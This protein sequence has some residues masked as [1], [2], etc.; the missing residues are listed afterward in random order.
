MDEAR[1]AACD[2]GT[3]DE[4]LRPLST[5]FPENRYFVP[6]VDSFMRTLGHH[7][8]TPKFQDKPIAQPKLAAADTRAAPIIFPDVIIDKD[9]SEACLKSH[10]T[11]MF[12]L[13]LANLA[14]GNFNEEVMTSR[15]GANTFAVLNKMLHEP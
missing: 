11:Q 5:E 15:L 3:F 12:T 13:S 9:L 4:R 7:H 14:A 1:R 8:Q 2:S 10:C 6:V